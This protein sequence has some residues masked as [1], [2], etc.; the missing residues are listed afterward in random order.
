[1]GEQHERPVAFGGDNDVARE[2]FE[3]TVRRDALKKEAAEQEGYI[4]LTV[5]YYENKT[6]TGAL[7]WKRYIDA[8]IAEPQ[9]T[10]RNS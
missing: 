6:I 3:G 1:M 7:L 8:L 10:E 4:Y 9:N 5:W 2:Q